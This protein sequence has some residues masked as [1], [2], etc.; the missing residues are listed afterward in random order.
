[1][2][3]RARASASANLDPGP[4]ATP[5]PTR[6][7]ADVC[8]ETRQQT[9][10]SHPSSLIYLGKVIS[11]LLPQVPHCPKGPFHPQILFLWDSAFG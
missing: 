11:P 3:G 6:C 2:T 10:G 8:E 4:R 5:A 7:S 1:M 9:N